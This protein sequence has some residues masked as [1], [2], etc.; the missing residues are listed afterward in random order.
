MFDKDCL[1]SLLVFTRK[2]FFS[3]NT[4]LFLPPKKK[5]FTWVGSDSHSPTFLGWYFYKKSQKKPISFPPF[6]LELTQ[7]ETMAEGLT[8]VL[9]L[10]SI[11]K[12][13]FLNDKVV[14]R[15]THVYL[16]IGL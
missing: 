6:F 12:L 5:K 4:A 1:F 15:L 2:E 13:A 11:L 16:S 8:L 9:K 14:H 10:S 7:W 3:L